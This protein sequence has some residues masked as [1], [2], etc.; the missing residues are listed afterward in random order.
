MILWKTQTGMSSSLCPSRTRAGISTPVILKTESVGS[1]LS[2]NKSYRVFRVWK[3]K[4]LN[5]I[6]RLTRRPFSQ[7]EPFLEINTALTAI[8]QVLHCLVTIA[9]N[10]ASVSDPDWSSLNLGALI[11]IECSG[12]H[13]NLGTHISKVRSLA[14]DD[15]P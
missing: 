3:V 12:I 5:T 14:L 4:N 6:L 7:Y 9:L 10:S 1:Q 13:R 2:N 11:C 8:L 15:W